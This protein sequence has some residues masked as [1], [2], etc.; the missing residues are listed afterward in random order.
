MEI[1]ENKNN[2]KDIDVLPKDGVADSPVPSSSAPTTHQSKSS[3][4]KYLALLVLIVVVAGLFYFL[5]AG[6]DIT[7]STAAVP[8]GQSEGGGPEVTQGNEPFPPRVDVDVQTTPPA[9][10]SL[11][12]GLECQDSNPCTVDTYDRNR[13]Q[14]THSS[15][16]N[17]CGNS[18]C[19][20]NERCNTETLETACQQDCSLSCPAF[21]TV[22]KFAAQKEPD[23]YSYNCVSGSC[24]AQGLNE[25]RIK[26]DAVVHTY[27]NNW[28]ELATENPVSA[29]TFCAYN[30]EQVKLDGTLFGVKLTDHFGGG[31]DTSGQISARTAKGQNY[32][33]YSIEVSPPSDLGNGVR[34]QC[35]VLLQ[36][37]EI[38]NSQNLLFVLS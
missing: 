7:G 8:S 17:C 35:T 15:V 28:G 22:S 14:C 25:F 16:A 37:T 20:Q 6:N 38:S 29:Q 5:R 24:D 31:K 19:E 36:S 27:I 3:S 11:T 12:V 1:S 10:K 32:A 9:R 33:E 26:G 13:G 34:I 23:K 21:L 30:G 4:K 18:V 2:E